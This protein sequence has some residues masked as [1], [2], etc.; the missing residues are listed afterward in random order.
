M[1]GCEIAGDGGFA[2][3]VTLNL[4]RAT[5]DLHC[6]GRQSVITKSSGR[7]FEAVRRG[8]RLTVTWARF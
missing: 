2:L 6:P 5:P 8:T 4:R 7:V 1:R 3:V